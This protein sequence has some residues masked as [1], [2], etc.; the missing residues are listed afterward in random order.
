M[1]TSNEPVPELAPE[2]APAPGTLASELELRL[3]AA[4]AEVA[5]LNDEFLR[6]KAVEARLK[7]TQSRDVGALQVVEPAFLPSA[8]A[9]PPV[10]RLILLAGLVSLLLAVVVVLLLEL[11]R[12]G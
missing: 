7:E 3:A 6:A 5:R 11:A 12:P 1:N 10:L 4:E 2:V 9:N 8:P